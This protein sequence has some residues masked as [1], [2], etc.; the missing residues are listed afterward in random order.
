V[1]SHHS[2]DA[3]TEANKKIEAFGI[4]SNMREDVYQ[5]LLKYKA[6]GEKLGPVDQRRTFLF[7][8]LTSIG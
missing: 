5:S 4:E 7:C 8:S 2:R 3:S 1:H 6:K